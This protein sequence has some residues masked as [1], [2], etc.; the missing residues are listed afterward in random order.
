MDGRDHRLGHAALRIAIN[1]APA[2]ISA[3]TSDRQLR[4]AALA[5]EHDPGTI[6]HALLVARRQLRHDHAELA[7]WLGIDADRLAALALEP[8]P[9]PSASD[10][11]DQVR[12][13]AERF[14][15]DPDRLADAL[16]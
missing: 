16:R 14:G 10:F 15:A 9:Y 5:A 13:L 7:R 6:A 4:Q 11:S 2:P 12:R 3:L 8:R 1:R